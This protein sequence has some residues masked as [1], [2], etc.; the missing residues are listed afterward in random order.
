MILKFPKFKI[1]DRCY[2]KIGEHTFYKITIVQRILI[3][4][5]NYY[6][7]DLSNIHSNLK[8][9]NVPEQYLS[10]S[11]KDKIQ[12]FP[13]NALDIWIKEYEL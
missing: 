1:G 8:I 5:S 3:N 12:N 9:N 10:K 11:I 4:T 6:T 2:I 7:I 13:S